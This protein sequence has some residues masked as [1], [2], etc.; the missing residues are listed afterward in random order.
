MVPFDEDE[1]DNGV[2]VS[3][4]QEDDER[5]CCRRAFVLRKKESHVI[6]SFQKVRSIWFYIIWQGSISVV[7]PQFSSYDPFQINW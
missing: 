3:Q 6:F 7:S 5:S 4:P 2:K 1:E